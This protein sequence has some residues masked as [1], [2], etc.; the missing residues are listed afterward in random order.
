MPWAGRLIQRAGK[1][2]N[3]HHYIWGHMTSECIIFFKVKV[4]AVGYDTIRRCISDWSDVMMEVRG[5]KCDQSWALRCV[6]WTLFG[7]WITLPPLYVCTLQVSQV[8]HTMQTD[9]RPPAGEQGS[10]SGIR[11]P[12]M[13][14]FTAPCGRPNFLCSAKRRLCFSSRL[15]AFLQP[16][17]R[18][19]ITAQLLTWQQVTPCSELYSQIQAEN[20]PMSVPAQKC[21]FHLY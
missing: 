17:Y 5:L 8:L 20:N 18:G 11:F 9:L 15:M 21:L 4:L 7:G 19:P 6:Q 12:S 2:F 16:L 1:W 13:L 10:Y 14:I 3:P